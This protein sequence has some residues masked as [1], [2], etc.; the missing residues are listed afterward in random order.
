M[1][2]GAGC[3][4]QDA[5][6]GELCCRPQHASARAGRT[7]NRRPSP[8]ASA[9]P[10]LPAQLPASFFAYRKQQHRWT[11]GPIQLWS[12]A[13]TDI[14]RS[15][16]GAGRG[17]CGCWRLGAVGGRADAAFACKPR[18]RPC[19]A[20]TLHTRPLAPPRALPQ[21]PFP[22][23]LELVWLYFGVRK[24]ATH[25]VSLGFFCTLVPLTVFTPEVGRGGRAGCW[26]LAVGGGWGLG[27]RRAAQRCAR[28]V[29]LPAPRRL[30]RP[31]TAL[32][33]SPSP[34]VSIPTWALVHLPVAV[35]LSTAAFTRRGWVYS[36]L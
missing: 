24:C 32:R 29:Q 17:A 10:C 19:F 18:A 36:I 25:F 34:Q 26:V 9:L 33:P 16:A 30:A 6:A 12:K 28:R 11:C 20:E 4:A 2:G 35:T 3:W 5:P 22:R 8:P 21:I 31:C 27:T 23:K 1:L 15:K 13:A 14:W 7:P